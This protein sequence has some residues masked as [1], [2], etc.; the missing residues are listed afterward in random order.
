MIQTHQEISNLLT[1]HFRRMAQEPGIDRMEAIDE[2]T[3]SIPKLITQEKNLALTGEISLEEA[4]ESV[5]EM[6]N[7]RAPGPD[8][9]T[10]KFYK[11]YWEIVKT[12]VWEVVEDSRCFTSILKSLNSTF[13]ALIPKEEEANTPSKFRAIALCNVLYKI[14]SKV[15]A[16][17]MKPILPGIILEEQ[18]GYVEGRDFGQCLTGTRDDS[19]TSNSEENR[20]DDATRPVKGV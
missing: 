4:E 5:K 8:G 15:I 14:I 11:A 19:H 12:K 18:S 2:L 10:I 13:L 16:N 9:F 3:S 20:Y 1:M 17:R 6:P 7:D